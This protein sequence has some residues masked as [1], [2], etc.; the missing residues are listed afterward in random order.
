MTS[1]IF[2]DFEVFKYNWLVTFVDVTSQKEMAIVDSPEKLKEFYNQNKSGIFVGYNNRHY[3]QYIFKAIMLGF[4]PKKVNDFIV[5][6][7]MDGW[8]YSNLF[9]KID[10]I[11]YDVA[12]KTDRG[13]KSFEGFMGH[14]I[15]ESSIPF[16]IE[17]PLTKS[18]IAETLKYNRHDVYETIEVFLRR[19]S[20]FDTMM[21][22]IRH[23]K[24]PLSDLNKTK[25]Q[26]TAKIL[27]G[28]GKGKYFNDEF[29]FPIVGCLRLGKYQHIGDWYRKPE[30]MDYDKY[31]EN[32]IA[33]VPHIN[34]WGGGHGALEK[35][36]AKGI[37]LVIDVTAYYP[38]LQDTFEF[39]FR[40]MD[41][42]ENFKFIHRSNIEFKRK[43]D[44]VKRQPFKILD[45]AI[46][47]QMKQKSSMLYDPMSNNAICINGQLLLIDLVEKLEGLVQL[48]QNNTDG[49]C[50]KLKSYDD[51]EKV[52]DIVYEWEQR[53]GMRMDIDQYFGEIFQKDVNNYLL[54]DRETGAMKRKGAYIKPLNDLDYDLPI[55]NKAM[56]EYMV[57]GVPV[58]K[59]IGDCDSLREFQQ[60]KKIG[61]KYECIVCDV[62]Y[63]PRGNKMVADYSVSRRLK[64]KCVR[65]FASTDRRDGGLG[66]IHAT[67]KKYAKLEGTPKHCFIE[68]GDVSDAKCPSKLDKS[69]YIELAK[70]RLSDYG[71]KL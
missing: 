62:G 28:N 9:R 50:A 23:F 20:E 38:S 48:V 53:T 71:V 22:F 35:Y 61:S 6:M 3:D 69:W 52:D 18:E 46:S 33:G 1:M 5:V 43:G 26:L 19:K 30:N 49:I 64:E 2:Y 24:L 57:N 4:D 37:F 15:K 51:F 56:I 65:V 31:Q 60:V 29:D 36:H 66:K 34:A 25:S 63:K 8:Q 42:S 10:M 27:G 47:G 67:T 13:L 21:Y 17:R 68:N 11:N 54:I 14:N 12:L 58:E 59:T 40:V 16:D 45:N 41:N 7:H 32:I 44:K 39:G 70:K 55:V